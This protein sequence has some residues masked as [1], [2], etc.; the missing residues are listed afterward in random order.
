MTNYG[1]FRNFEICL[2]NTYPCLAPIQKFHY[3]RASLS[4]R[5]AQDIFVFLGQ[6]YE[7]AWNPLCNRYYNRAVL[8]DTHERAPLLHKFNSKLNKKRSRE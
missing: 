2:I 5:A 3:L 1:N 4:D 6:K 8:V 7:I